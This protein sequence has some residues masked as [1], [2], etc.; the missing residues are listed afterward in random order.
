MSRT[1]FVTS[2]EGET[3]KSTVAYGLLDLLSRQAGRIAVF[4]PVTAA[5]RDKVVDL[6]LSHPAVDQSYEDAIGVTYDALH[7]DEQAALGMILQRRDAVA[8]NA[9]VVLALGSDFADVSTGR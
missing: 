1:V 8:Q 2:A 9:D 3:G 4:R 6:L 7:D 5:R